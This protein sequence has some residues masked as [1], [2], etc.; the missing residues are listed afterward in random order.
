[1][2]PALAANIQEARIQQ[3]LYLLA[4]TVAQED[5]FGPIVEADVTSGHTVTLG[6][7]T[8]VEQEKLEVSVL[9]ST[10]GE[11]WLD[12]PLADFRQKFY[13]GRYEL[14]LDPAAFPGIR[15]LR[16]KWRMRRWGGVSPKE[17]MFGFYV[18]IA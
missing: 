6:I 4:E 1:M 10:D 5:G 3:Q 9:G 17:P 14:P 16:V 12:Q 7:T 15:H 11:H 2:Q 8:T 13:C 18:A